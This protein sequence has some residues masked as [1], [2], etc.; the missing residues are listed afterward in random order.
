MKLF[1]YKIFQDIIKIALNLLILKTELNGLV[2]GQ[3]KRNG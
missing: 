3:K 1:L 2:I